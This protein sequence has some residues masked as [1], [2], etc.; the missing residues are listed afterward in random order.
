MAG[1]IYL[2]RSGTENLVYIGQTMRFEDRWD[3]HVLAAFIGSTTPFHQAIRRLG[4]SDF[5]CEILAEAKT[6]EE[7]NLLEKR[8]IAYYDA[9]DPA[10]GYN[11]MVGGTS[12]RTLR[13]EE[14][15]VPKGM[16]LE[17]GLP[18][19]NCYGEFIGKIR[20]QHALQMHGVFLQV[21]ARGTGRRRHFTSAKL[22]ARRTWRWEP[23]T[24]DGFIVMQ[25][26]RA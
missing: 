14:A 12:S 9:T 20:V 18:L 8:F 24:S 2:H 19:Y 5:S 17:Q 7:L 3:E 11:V 4:P 1:V 26:V 6:R 15:A 21:R 23:K 13:P 10:K 22:Y 16:P 25:L